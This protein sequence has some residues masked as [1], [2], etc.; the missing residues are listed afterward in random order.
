[1]PS[2]IPYS[3]AAPSREEIDARRGLLLLDF[4]TNWCGH[5]HAAQEP[6]AA[7]LA[8]YPDLQHIRVEDGPGR[9]LGRSFRVKLWP[10]LILLRDGR[11]LDRLVRPTETAAVAQWLARHLPLA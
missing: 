6:V 5:C 11:E 7:A 2:S 8:A 3:A 4:G 10:T 1:M 9:P